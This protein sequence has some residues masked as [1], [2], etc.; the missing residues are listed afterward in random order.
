MTSEECLLDAILVARSKAT[1]L[2]HDHDASSKPAV[3]LRR[4]GC[5]SA[6]VGKDLG[7]LSCESPLEDFYLRVCG[8]YQYATF[9]FW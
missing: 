8:E 4:P 5:G 9:L 7:Q 1:E 6:P 2:W 3:F